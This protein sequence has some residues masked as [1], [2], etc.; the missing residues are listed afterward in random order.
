[1]HMSIK[2]YELMFNL[3]MAEQNN[4]LLLKTIEGSLK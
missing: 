3:L 1:M 4:E 2:C